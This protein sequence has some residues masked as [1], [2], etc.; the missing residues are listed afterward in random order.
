MSL[1]VVSRQEYSPTWSVSQRRS[2]HAV[3]GTIPI[4]SPLHF[5][6]MTAREAKPGRNRGTDPSPR[7]GAARE[8]AGRRWY[9]YLI[10]CRN[11]AIYTGIALDV[12]ARYAQHVAG[13][14]ARYTRAHPP[15]R[16]L[17]KFACADQSMASRMEA[18]IK[19]LPAAAKRELV[20]KAG[21]AARKRLLG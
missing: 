2:G 3:V 18:A 19:K 21:R 5:K 16:L 10:V 4:A 14:G 9:V 11:G 13:K 12:S 7:A 17:G 15:I 1:H 20:G 6:T 8:R